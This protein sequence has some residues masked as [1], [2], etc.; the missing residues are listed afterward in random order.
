MNWLYPLSGF[1]VG[2][3]VGLT[4]V[5]GGS[6][7]TPLLML[8][9]GFSPATAV[10]TDLLYASIT[11][12][13]GSLAHSR[14][15]TVRWN[16]V[17][18][19]ALGSLPAALLTTVALHKLGVDTGSFNKL[20]TTGL[21]IALILTAIS[22]IFKSQLLR[23]VEHRFPRESGAPRNR[24]GIT[25]LIG[26]L[27]GVLVTISSVGAGALGTLALV[28]LYPRMP[29]VQVVGTDIAHAVP[30]TL[31]AG[32]GHAALGTVDYSLLLSLLVG[33]LPGIWLGSRLSVRLPERHL[34]S[35]LAAMLLIIGGK[36]VL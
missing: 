16:V 22:L 3:I 6:L 19:L 13:G 30:L 15:R 12:S 14:S 11:K 33:S 24:V 2:L 32:L 29:A 4:G 5:G 8:V 31:V 18:H 35:A 28:L 36:F 20:I 1:A 25:I 23:W 9:F 26:A 34:R 21:G 17:G 7:M 10:G 27:L